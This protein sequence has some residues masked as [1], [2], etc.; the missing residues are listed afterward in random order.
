MVMQ[1]L[2][3][4]TKKSADQANCNRFILVKSQLDESIELSQ[5]TQSRKIQKTA[6]WSI[7]GDKCVKK[8][9]GSTRQ[10]ETN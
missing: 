5:K 4:C 10:T 3:K 8:N 9:C 2:D 6:C 1:R 7:Y